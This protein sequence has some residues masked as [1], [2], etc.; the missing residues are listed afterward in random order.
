MKILLLSDSH[1][2]YDELQAVIDEWRDA[3]D[4]IFHLGDSELPMTDPL[5]DRVDAVVAGNMDFHAG[6]LAEAT[7]A[8]EEGRA[9]LIHGHLH[10]LDQLHYLAEDR[11]VEMIFHGHTHRPYADY[12][13]GLLRVNP[14]SLKHNRASLMDRSYAVVSYSANMVQVVFYSPLDHRQLDALVFER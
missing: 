2:L 14:G 3:V 10:P 9:L 4:Y 8:T 13:A 7:I 12:D 11:Q 5:W 1:R 6:Y